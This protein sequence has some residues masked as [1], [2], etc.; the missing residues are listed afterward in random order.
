MERN[1]FQ[2][3]TSRIREDEVAIFP[4]QAREQSLLSLLCAAGLQ[5]PDYALRNSNN[6][7]A[8]LRFHFGDLKLAANAL[9]RLVHAEGAF[10]EINIRPSEA[11]NFAV[12]QS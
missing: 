1:W 2:R 5:R 6:A 3:A 11:E 4:L 8:T 9:E 12:P 7:S 10:L